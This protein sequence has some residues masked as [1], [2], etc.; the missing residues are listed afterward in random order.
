MKIR[1]IL[2]AFF[3]FSL[4]LNPVFAEHQ[5][6]MKK[7]QQFKKMRLIELLD[8]DEAA[9]EK[10]FVRYNSFEK[11]IHEIRKQLRDVGKAISEGVE[12]GKKNVGEQKE[13]EIL[14]LIDELASV[15][16]EKLSSLKSLLNQ[17]QYSKLLAFEF[18]FM[19]E[20]QEIFSKRLQRSR[21]NQDR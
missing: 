1:F 21:R 15:Q 18:T 16:K 3:I 6:Q 14:K 19:D 12:S 13:Q 8:F 9:S 2:F 5:G 7:L 10:F 11:R 17:E 20:V 4:L